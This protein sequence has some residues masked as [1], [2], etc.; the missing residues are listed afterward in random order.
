MI[1]QTFLCGAI[2]NS[3]LLALPQESSNPCNRSQYEN[4]NQVDPAPLVLRMLSG[5]VMY[6]TGSRSKKVRDV[7]PIFG[8]YLTLFSEKDHQIVAETVANSK[9]YFTFDKLRTGAYRLIARDPDGLL[10]VANIPV[11]INEGKKYRK[12]DRS[13]IVIHMRTAA[14]DDCSYG[15]LK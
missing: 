13:Q 10:C 7:N 6:Q 2:I 11:V 8:A 15:E 3:L 14:I 9:G 12:G 5:R 4:K 1:I